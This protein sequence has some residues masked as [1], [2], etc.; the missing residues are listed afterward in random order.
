M[1][2]H[3]PLILILILLFSCSSSKQEG[4]FREISIWPNGEISLGEKFQQKDEVSVQVSPYTFELIEETFGGAGSIIVF[5]DSLY[6]VER[7]RFQYSVDYNFDEESVDYRSALGVPE[8]VITSD[9][10]DLIIWKDEKT[11][12][13]MGRKK[14]GAQIIN[15]SILMDNL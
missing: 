4:I 15:Y 11:T 3:F 13:E 14:D 10:L 9:T 8:Q 5:T 6:Q 1:T 7:I 2:N 12:F